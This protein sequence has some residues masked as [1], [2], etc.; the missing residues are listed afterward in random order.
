[1]IE[2]LRG[3][4]EGYVENVDILTI[5]IHDYGDDV[6]LYE[7]DDHHSDAQLCTILYLAHGNVEKC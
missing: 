3:R 1:M 5:L 6:Q 2:S 7:N 4:G